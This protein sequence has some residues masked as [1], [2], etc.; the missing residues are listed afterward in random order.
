M[1]YGRTYPCEAG[2]QVIRCDRSKGTSGFGKL[3]PVTGLPGVCLCS[4]TVFFW[5]FC[6]CKIS[7]SFAC[8][9]LFPVKLKF[10][11][12]SQVSMSP[13]SPHV[14]PIVESTSVFKPDIFKG[15]VL[16]CTGG[17]SGICRGM[18]ETMVRIFVTLFDR[19]RPRLIH[20]LGV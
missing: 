17:G 3:Q 1:R 16:F 12:L 7:G 20:G 11:H 13:S 4:L 2:H 6:L 14:V 9:L 8:V 10:F 19:Y 18:T 15:K 5:L